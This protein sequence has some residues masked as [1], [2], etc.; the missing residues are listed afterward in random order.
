MSSHGGT[1]RTLVLTMRKTMQWSQ[2]RLILLAFSAGA[3]GVEAR[4]EGSVYPGDVSH[5]GGDV[6]ANPSENSQACVLGGIKL[7]GTGAPPCDKSGD[8]RSDI[9]VSVSRCNRHS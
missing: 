8:K 9:A 5:G 4:E 6:T 1:P 2:L 7:G 3:P